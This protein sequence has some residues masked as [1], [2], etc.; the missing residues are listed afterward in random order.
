VGNTTPIAGTVSFPNQNTAGAQSLTF[1]YSASSDT[2]TP[3][4]FIMEAIQ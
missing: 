3:K 1:S 2:I 4:G